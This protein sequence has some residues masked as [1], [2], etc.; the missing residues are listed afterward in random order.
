MLSSVVQ[1]LVLG[2]TLFDIFIDDIR[3]V[4]L[5]ALIQ[6]FADDTK[7][8]TTIENEND[9][10]K[11]Q[12]IIDNLVEWADKWKMA[13]NTKKCKIIHVG[14]NNPRIKYYMKGNEL[15]EANDEKDLGVFVEAKMKP[16]KQCNAAAK[17]AN[18]A[19]GQ[20]QRAFHFRKKDSI[21]PL[22]KTFVRP[23]LEYASSA[24]C[25]WMEKDKKQLEK[26]QERLIRM[27]SDVKGTNYEEKLKD[28]GLTTLEKRRERGDVI[29]AFKTIK[30]F[31]R[32]Q[33][34]KWF[35]F[36]PEDA[37]PTRSNTVVTEDG[38]K[39]R[40]FV[41]KGETARLDTRK[42]FYTVRITKEWNRIP[43]W[44]KEKQSVNAFKNAYDKWA[45]HQTRQREDGEIE[46]EIAL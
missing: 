23:K 15:E 31:N 6:M 39:R 30:G 18:F 20:I 19:L 4:V 32:V 27:I 24:W 34:D 37:R 43:D 45:S 3:T 38:E 17:S 13:F 1:G 21:V 35:S 40:Q 25:P 2:G 42:Y 5:D 28:A 10:I 44:V 14:H 11:M 41:M 9:G 33:K 8:A 12:K 29:E 36:E 26:V 7:V 46:E 22:Y 16:G